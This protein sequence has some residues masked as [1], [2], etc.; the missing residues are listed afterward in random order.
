MVDSLKKYSKP[1]VLHASFLPLF[2]F[3]FLSPFP[4][5]LTLPLSQVVIIYGGCWLKGHVTEEKGALPGKEGR[6]AE[7]FTPEDETE[8]RE[9][10]TAMKNKSRAEYMSEVEEAQTNKQKEIQRE[11]RNPP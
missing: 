1:S 7:H 11:E 6:T 4:P 9:G 3:L 2:L 10:Q 8:E 5:S